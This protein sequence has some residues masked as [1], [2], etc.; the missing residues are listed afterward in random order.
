MRRC[1]LLCG[2]GGGGGGAMR[3]CNAAAELLRLIATTAALARYAM[4]A[5]AAAMQRK[6]YKRRAR[7]VAAGVGGGAAGVPRCGCRLLRIAAMLC[8]RMRALRPHAPLRTA[9]CYGGERTYMVNGCCG[10]VMLCCRLR[11]AACNACAQ[12]CARYGAAVLLLRLLPACRTR[13]A[14]ALCYGAHACACMR[15]RTAMVI[16]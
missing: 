7:P 9:L 3:L 10:C 15:M 5:A 14:H 4:A 11:H 12:S 8:M 13:Y 1:R 2:G 16:D 6:R